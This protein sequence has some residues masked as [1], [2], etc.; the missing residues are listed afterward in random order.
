MTKN[1]KWKR[2]LVVAWD[3]EGANKDGTHIYNL[4]ANSDG[5]RIVNP[6]GLSTR[7]VLDFFVDN[8]R[9]QAINVIYGGSY[10][11]NMFLRDVPPENLIALW[12]EGYCYWH[13]YRIFYTPRKKFT[14]YRYHD[15]EQKT[16]R[17]EFVLWDV[18]GYFQTSFV[19]ATRKWLGDSTLLDDIEKMKY[20]R[21]EFTEDRLEDIIEYN[22]R[23]CQILVK[24]MEA[25]FA[26]LD[27]ADI[28]LK[29]YDGAGSIAAA[30]LAKNKIIKHKGEQD[31]E[32][33]K[34]AQYAYSGGRIE[35]TK[36]G[37][38]DGRIYRNDI[39]SAY[40][41][42]ARSLPSYHNCTWEYSSEI[43]PTSSSMVHVQWHYEKELPFYPLW[44]RERDGSILY[45]RWGEGVY[46]YAEIAEALAQFPNDIDVLGCYSCEVN[47]AVKPFAFLQDT[48]DIRLGFKQQGNMASEALKLGMNSIYGKL[49]Q[50]L[51]WRNGKPPSYHQLLWA[52][53]ITAQCRATLY[54]AAMQK[55]D[56]VIAFA[57]DAVLTTEPLDLDCGIGLGQWTPEVFDGITIV[58]AGVY[59]LNDNGD[60]HDKYRGFDKGALNRQHIVNSWRMGMDHYQATLTRFVTLGSALSSIDFYSKWRTW[61]TQPR[62]LN[63][64]PTGKRMAS[65]QR[66]YWEQL[67][68]TLPQVNLNIDV[69]SKPYPLLWIEGEEGLFGNRPLVNDLDMKIVEE[70]YLDSYA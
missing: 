18:I 69:I 52:G 25:L 47:E 29:R 14:V 64:T 6:D 22:S 7:E 20:Q 39:N 12:V 70:E 8:G 38:F 68:D 61:D 37:N 17:D 43:I 57:T 40:P 4:L 23:E 19:N 60:W 42:F 21:S 51:G 35:A 28:Q 26:A 53:Q 48:Y 3:G 11:V 2:R 54:R 65:E 41:A 10:D 30:L 49:A 56:S 9:K 31:N 24:L 46:W 55:P 5:D 32:V 33:K 13:E 50:Q 27:T 34:W 44:Y 1:S 15:V 36:I 58:Q 59:W 45:P 66:L 67:C 62:V 16:K 63:I